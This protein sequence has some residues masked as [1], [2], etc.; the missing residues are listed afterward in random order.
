MSD[1]LK[2]DAAADVAA[3]AKKLFKPPYRTLAIAAIAVM[4]GAMIGSI[5]TGA[6]S[7]SIG[8]SPLSEEEL[9]GIASNILNGAEISHIQCGVGPNLCEVLA[10]DTLLYMDETGRYGIAGN[11]LDFETRTDLTAQREQELRRFAAFVGGEDP[12]PAAAPSPAA[13]AAAAP[14]PQGQPQ[15]SS[16]VEVTL[17]VENAV[18]YNGGQGLPVLHVF[19]DLNCSF[20]HR[21]HQETP[22]LAQYEIREYFLEWLGPSSRQK[23]LLVLCADDREAAANEMYADGGAAITR[24]LAECEADFGDIIDANTAFARSFGL[25][26]TPA[27][28]FEDGRQIGRGYAPAAQIQQ[29]ISAS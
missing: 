8:S 19:S 6:T 4:G 5:A 14:A 15:Q 16:F 3:S 28:Y 18:V 24:S 2:N 26:G 13:G 7:N 21:L 12:A 9:R 11:L 25:Q 20:C 23:A 22:G 17:P 1:E 10:E 27:M 29:E